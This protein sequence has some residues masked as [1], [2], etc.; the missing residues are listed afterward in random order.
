M[1]LCKSVFSHF[2]K[3]VDVNGDVVRKST[4]KQ[5]LQRRTERTLHC[6]NIFTQ[7]HT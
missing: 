4:Q 3:Y 6:A 2:G 5:F 7:Q 1:S